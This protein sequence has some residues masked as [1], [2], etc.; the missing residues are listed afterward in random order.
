MSKKEV[1]AEDISLTAIRVIKEI[2]EPTEDFLQSVDIPRNF[3]IGY[4]YEQGVNIEREAIRGRLFITIS[5]VGEDNNPLGLESEF[6]F[7]FIFSVPNIESFI[8]N[9]IEEKVVL[10]GSLSSVIASIVYSTA[11]GILWEKLGSTLFGQVLLPVINPVTLV[12]LENSEE[13]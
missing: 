4:N 7:D 11:R 6:G 9:R 12:K 2:I 1:R 8:E 10:N 5:A 3:Q 13:N